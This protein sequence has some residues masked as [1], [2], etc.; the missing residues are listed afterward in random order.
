MP[1]TPA[2]LASAEDDGGGER[3]EPAAVGVEEVA[4][5]KSP[6]VENHPEGGTPVGPIKKT[7]KPSQIHQEST[8]LMK[9]VQR[10]IDDVHTYLPS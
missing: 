7:K 9:G 1:P 4:G 5:R 3:S 8:F 6:A 2:I 10:P